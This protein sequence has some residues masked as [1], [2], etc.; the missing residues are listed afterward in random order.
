MPQIV[1]IPHGAASAKVS[2]IDSTVRLGGI[3]AEFFFTPESKV[4]GFDV[5][6]P[7][8]CWVILVE[9]CS[10]KKLLYDL[11]IRK[12]WHNLAEPTATRIKSFNWDVKIEKDVP[13]IL[14]ENGISLSEINYIV[15]R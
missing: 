6:P 11:G 9:H 7:L 3:S 10:G 8:P 4:Q 1:N 2:F 5:V 12:D 15:W 14:E 13:E